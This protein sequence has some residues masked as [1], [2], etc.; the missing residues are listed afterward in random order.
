MGGGVRT[1]LWGSL[2]L[3][4]IRQWEP[5]AVQEDHHGQIIVML[6]PALLLSYI[7]E[8]EGP[9]RCPPAKTVAIDFKE[10]HESHVWFIYSCE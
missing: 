8:Q 3:L 6:V 2:V 7:L 10:Q 1:D 4:T 5:P 9:E